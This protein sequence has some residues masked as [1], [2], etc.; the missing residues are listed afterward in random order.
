MTSPI[1][2]NWEVLKSNRENSKLEEV[3]TH[4]IFLTAH[5]GLDVQSD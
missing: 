1:Q 3:A 5:P 4:D 2:K